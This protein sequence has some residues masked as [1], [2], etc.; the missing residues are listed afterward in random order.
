MCINYV[1]A[2]TRQQIASTFWKKP[3]TQLSNIN[4]TPKSSNH[5]YAN[6]LNHY[7]DA[8][9][10]LGEDY[11]DDK[12]WVT[13]ERS[14]ILLQEAMTKSQRMRGDDTKERRTKKYP[15]SFL[16]QSYLTRYTKRNNH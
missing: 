3:N 10:V 15:V 1:N 14:D 9:T 13:R 7:L 11:I 2:S 4:T 12:R 5:F 16:T 8:N 6:N